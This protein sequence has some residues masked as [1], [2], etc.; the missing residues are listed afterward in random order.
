MEKLTLKKNGKI[1]VKQ[2]EGEYT[3]PCLICKDITGCDVEGNK[4]CGLYK[5]IEKLAKYENYEMTPEQVV[6]LSDL[7]FKK[8]MEI[9]DLKKLFVQRI[10]RDEERDEVFKQCLH[11]Y[12][13]D[14]QIDM[15]LK[16]M[17]EL[18]KALLK[19]KPFGGSD[20]KGWDNIIDE[21]ADVRIMVRQ[22]EI[23]F[24][25]ENEV[26]SRID[27][28]VQRQAR[29]LKERNEQSTSDTI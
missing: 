8:M 7:H 9:A 17:S 24:Q 18:S 4:A 13:D 27:Y 12:G 28:K 19:N 21:L 1:L 23:L 15:M 25:C 22:M 20:P 14:P 26:E 11:I 16:E 5:A 29:R 6:E 2:S 3:E 10:R